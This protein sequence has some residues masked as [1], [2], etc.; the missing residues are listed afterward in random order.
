MSISDPTSSQF[1][2]VDLGCCARFA[3]DCAAINSRALGTSSFPLKTR[4]IS[5][6]R[7]LSSDSAVIG[8]VG[9]A[10]I[11]AGKIASG[12]FRPTTLKPFTRNARNMA[13]AE[14][15]EDPESPESDA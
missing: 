12:R 11:L 1:Y 9:I 6:S 3:N 13:P 14:A 5:S 4:A 8:G 7:G 15:A 10:D 2:G